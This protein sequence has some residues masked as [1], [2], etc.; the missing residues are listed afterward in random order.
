MKGMPTGQYIPGNSILHRLDARAKI[1]CMFILLAA[2]IVA[3]TIWGYA[4]VILITAG[5][6]FAS[7]LPVQAVFGTLRRLWLFFIIIFIMNTVFFDGE[8]SAWS[9]WIFNLSAAGAAQGATVVFRLALLLLLSNCLTSTTAPMDAT[10][11][12][13]SLMKPLGLIRVPVEDIA[14]IISVAIQFI[15]TLIEE[16]DMIRKAQIARGARFESKKLKEKAASVMP[17]VIPV[18][19][20]AFRRAD[21]LSTA[22]EARGYRNAKNRTKRKRVP[23]KVIDYT[24]LAGSALVCAVQICI[25]R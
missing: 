1:L 18:F 4:L 16:T 8:K 13:E 12:L 5:I 19:I 24:A 25:F 3:S 21:E 22:M 15:P 23:M 10:N 6:G 9:W 14:M 11:A 7:E 20:S 2:I 17:L